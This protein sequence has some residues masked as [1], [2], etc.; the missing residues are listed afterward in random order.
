M[1]RKRIDKN[2]RKV[3]VSVGIRYKYVKKIKEIS[4]NV[5]KFLDKLL[6]DYFGE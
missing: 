2:E 3:K 4:S 1:G 6:K 5:S